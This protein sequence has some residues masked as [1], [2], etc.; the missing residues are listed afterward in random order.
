MDAMGLSEGNELLDPILGD[1]GGE[2]LKDAG[3]DL[4]GITDCGVQAE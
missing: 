2:G 3:D 4:T 1:H